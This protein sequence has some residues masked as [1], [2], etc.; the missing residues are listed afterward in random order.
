MAKYLVKVDKDLEELIPGFVE[1]RR[2]EI[3]ELGPLLAEKKFEDIT[4]LAH[5]TKG[6][7]GGYGFMELSAWAA[8]LEKAAKAQDLQI[9]LSCHQKMTEFIKDFEVVFVESPA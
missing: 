3:S 7:S 9:C 1:N 6:S 5:K 2:K 8:E 4:K